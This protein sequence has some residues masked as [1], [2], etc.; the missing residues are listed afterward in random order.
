M[1]AVVQLVKSASV[2]DQRYPEAINGIQY[3]LVVLL[4]VENQDTFQDA[5]KIAEKISKLRVF[6]DS[7]GKMNLSLDQ[8]GGSVLLVS[9]FTLVADLKG[10]NRPSFIHAAKEDRALPL[11]QKVQ[12][13]IS[14]K[15]IP[16]QTGFFGENMGLELNLSGP[17]TIVL[18]THDF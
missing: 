14:E 5:Q 8:V 4:G 18:D 7:D 11:Y 2:W 12:E 17:V 3:G 9:Q 1:I 13:I 15:G 16:V 10:F 6:P